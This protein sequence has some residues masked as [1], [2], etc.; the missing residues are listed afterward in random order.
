MV[1]INDAALRPLRLLLIANAH[2]RALQ[3][4]RHR[5][6]KDTTHPMT[7]TRPFEL[8]PTMFSI[9]HLGMRYETFSLTR[10][11]A[12]KASGFLKLHGYIDAAPK[13]GEYTLTAKGRSEY[14]RL[15][16]LRDATTAVTSNA[17]PESAMSINH[18][19]PALRVAGQT[20]HVGALAAQ[21]Q[22][23]IN[24]LEKTIDDL[25]RLLDQRADRVKALENTLDQRGDLIDQQTGQIEAQRRLIS[26]LNQQIVDLGRSA[27]KADAALAVQILDEL[28]DM[29]PEVETYR[30][31]R[32][33]AV[34]AI[35]TLKARR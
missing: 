16:A 35:T 18:D 8:T 5:Q 2:R 15:K 29:L 20:D 32:E 6:Q 24:Q 34:K 27:H 23:R 26:E 1:L 28:C 3:R 19:D 22:V 30:T 11:Q 7:D 33:N 13:K 14:E 17:A 10:Q 31:A 4:H 21:R 12:G 25:N 9:L